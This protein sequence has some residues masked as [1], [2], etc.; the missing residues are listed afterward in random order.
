MSKNSISGHKWP[1]SFWFCHLE[2]LSAT[3]LNPDL[4]CTCRVWKLSILVQS[5]PKCSL[6]EHYPTVCINIPYNFYL[7]R[8]HMLKA[9]LPCYYSLPLSGLIF[10]KICTPTPSPLLQTKTMSESSSAWSEHRAPD[11]R[12]Y[13]YNRY[14]VLLAIDAK[15]EWLIDW[16]QNVWLT[17]CIED[18][19]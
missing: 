11:G 3:P 4:G 9:F 16:M 14:L 1:P 2:L 6:L 19:V 8:Q 15:W 12:T 7:N 10:S 13:F 18:T 5:K 17:D